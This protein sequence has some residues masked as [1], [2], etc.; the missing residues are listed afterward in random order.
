MSHITEQRKMESQFKS[1]KISWTGYVRV[2]IISIVLLSVSV[3]IAVIVSEYVR[4][5]IDED[6]RSGIN[7]DKNW[8]FVPTGVAVVGWSLFGFFAWVT[9][10]DIAARR[11]YTLYTDQDGVW[12]RFGFLPWQK[13]VR[14]VRWEDMDSAGFRGGLLAWLFN[15]YD[16]I[17]THRFTKS[18]EIA[19]PS[20]SYGKEAVAHIEDMRE[21]YTKRRGIDVDE[22]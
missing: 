4:S 5:E 6:L 14:G 11:A 15:S 2:A 9:I 21:L 8:S 17:V 20:I 7:L 16:V 19:A 10:L 22:P 12:L 13:G 18:S 3:F 1:Y